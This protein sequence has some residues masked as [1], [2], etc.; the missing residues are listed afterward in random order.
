MTSSGGPATLDHRQRA[1]EVVLLAG[2][3]TSF[4][5][6]FDRATD[7]LFRCRMSRRRLGGFGAGGAADNQPPRAGVVRPELPDVPHARRQ[8][9][10]QADELRRRRVDSRHDHQAAGESGHRRRAGDGD[11]AVQG[12]AVGPGNPRAGQTGARVRQEPGGQTGAPRPSP[13]RKPAP[14]SHPLGRTACGPFRLSSHSQPS[15][16][17]SPGPRRSRVDRWHI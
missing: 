6:R 16:N 5:G 13:R 7:C 14:A 3:I 17:R 4:Q 2:L 1:G 12:P 8:R 15:G 9:G 11:D 10:H